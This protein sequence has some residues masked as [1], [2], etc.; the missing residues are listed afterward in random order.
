MLEGLDAFGKDAE[1]G[2]S[3][4]FPD[5]SFNVFAANSLIRLPSEEE[6]ILPGIDKPLKCEEDSS[7]RYYKKEISHLKV[8][9]ATVSG[10]TL[11]PQ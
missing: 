2:D 6:G 3:P 9:L 11:K 10:A 5:I 4:K 1:R 7:A 8:D